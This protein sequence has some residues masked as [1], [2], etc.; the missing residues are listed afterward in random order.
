MLTN[1]LPSPNP[2]ERIFHSPFPL[3]VDPHLRA[4]RALGMTLKTLDAGP[5]E[6]KGDYIKHGAVLGTLAV[7][8]RALG[9]GMPVLKKGGDLKQLGGEFVLGPG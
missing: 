1:R 4:Y 7:V 2:T 5:Q 8:G 6:A 3:Y 9:S